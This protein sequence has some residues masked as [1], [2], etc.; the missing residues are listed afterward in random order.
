[1]NAVNVADR[2]CR[3]SNMRFP[4]EKDLRAFGLQKFDELYSMV[5][6]L[7][8][9]PP[10]RVLEVGSA[11]GGTFLAWCECATDDATLVSVDVNQFDPDQELMRS[12]AKPTQTVHFIRGNSHESA[13][14]LQVKEIS[15]EFDFL[16]IDADHCEAAVRADWNDYSPLVPRGGFVGFHD[17]SDGGPIGDLWKELASRYPNMKFI[18]D[19]GNDGWG[20]IGVLKV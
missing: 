18:Q 16:F 20:G 6:Y 7:S 2:A 11:A 17:I 8:L 14:R 1:M 9:T 19:N 5:C 15:E 10:A 3:A 4:G 13:T 12:Y